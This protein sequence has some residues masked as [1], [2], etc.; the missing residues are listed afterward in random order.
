[1]T[2]L[3][4]YLEAYI[5]EKKGH[6]ICVKTDCQSIPATEPIQYVFIERVIDTVERKLPALKTENAW[7]EL[8]HTWSLGYFCADRQPE[9]LS[10]FYL[11]VKELIGEYGLFLIIDEIDRLF[12]RV[13]QSQMKYHR[14]LDSLFGSVSE[15]L[16]SYACRKAVHL[17][18]CGSNWLIR[19]NLKGDRKN[20]LF[21][22]FGKQVLEVG[23]LP[24]NDAKELLYLPY[25]PYPQLIITEEAVKWIWDYAGGLVWHTK[26]LGEE[27]VE[28]AKEN[29]RYVVYPSDVRQSIP[30]VITD[31]WCKQFY[32]GCEEGE[33]RDL[34]DAMQS[35]AAKKDAYV[36]LNQL[37][38]LMS[39]SRVEIQRVVKVLTGLK[40]LSVHPIDSQLYKFELD[41][42]RRYFR[43]NSSK[44]GQVPEEPDIFQIRQPETGSAESR[45]AVAET[46]DDSEWYDF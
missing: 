33:E 14:N 12:E 39:I 45:P 1:M 17:V 9:K 7:E 11:D 26:L 42:Y 43:T 5:G 13:E 35:L 31:L 23:K 4:N 41:I 28:R 24:E 36:H 44:Y 18:I 19:Y 38:E 2:S 20:Q 8:K 32:E 27:A 40:I 34:V 22:R 15:I 30:K 37:S 16:N 46:S 3:L 6:I 29:G 10:L 25:R 21:Q